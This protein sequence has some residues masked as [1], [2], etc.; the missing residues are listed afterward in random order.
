[1]NK[2]GFLLYDPK[3]FFAVAAAMFVILPLTLVW[4]FRF[5]T[6]AMGPPQPYTGGAPIQ[7]VFYPADGS[8]V[9]VTSTGAIIK[10]GQNGNPY[11]EG[12]IDPNTI[13]SINSASDLIGKIKSGAVNPYTQKSQVSPQ[14]AT[15]AKPSATTSATASATAS[16]TATASANIT[17]SVPAP[18]VVSPSSR[19]QTVYQPTRYMPAKPAPTTSNVTYVTYTQ[20]QQQQQQQQTSPVTQAA[21]TQSTQP[22]Y[23]NTGKLPNTGPGDVLAIGGGATILATAGHYFYQR[24]RYRY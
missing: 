9:T 1:M 18:P 23:S 14:P 7:K 21:Q 22:S 13:S 16:S 3:K 6:V 17:F 8:T 4:I 15:S 24:L 12:W 2:L 20:P 11:R 19:T 10:Q 5:N